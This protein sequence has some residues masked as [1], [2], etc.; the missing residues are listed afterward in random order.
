MRRSLPIAE[1]SSQFECAAAVR[2]FIQAFDD[3]HLRIEE[4]WH[5]PATL[6]WRGATWS[7]MPRTLSAKEARQ[8][9][10]I[11]ESPEG[12]DLDFG[13]APLFEELLSLLEE[14]LRIRFAILS[15]RRR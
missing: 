7:Q 11:D 9:F 14:A 12:F 1:A 15:E 8:R 6:L 13:E 10:G 5:S 3:P 2:K 4:P